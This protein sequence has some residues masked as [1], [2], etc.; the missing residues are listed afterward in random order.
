MRLSEILV[1]A[2]QSWA[3]LPATMALYNKRTVNLIDAAGAWVR[4]ATILICKNEQGRTCFVSSTGTDIKS[5]ADYVGKSYPTHHDQTGSSKGIYKVV[6]VVV[7]QGDEITDKVND[8]G[9]KEKASL[10]VF[11]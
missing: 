3:I 2:Q 7:V 4:G 6:N 10:S 8:V 9:L 5:Y 1:E 11:K